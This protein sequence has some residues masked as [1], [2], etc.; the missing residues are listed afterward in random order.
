MIASPDGRAARQRGDGS[1]GDSSGGGALLAA[2]GAARPCAAAIAVVVV[3]ASSGSAG[4]G[5]VTAA[6]HPANESAAP[7]QSSAALRPGPQRDPAAGLEAPHRAGADPRVPRARRRAGRR[8]LP[9]A[10]R[11]PPGLPPPDGLARRTRLPGG[12]PRT[13]RAGLVPRRHAAAQAGRPLLRRR[14]PAAVHLRPAAS[15]A[16]TA[17]RA[18]STS[19]PKART[20]TPATSSDDRRRLGAGRPHDPPPRPDRHWTPNS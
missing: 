9:R 20:S 11:T 12:H 4:S 14:L 8:A 3:V 16:S 17:G 6:S 19:R 1:G 10:V 13:G 5:D 7:G 15:C 18:C 2:G